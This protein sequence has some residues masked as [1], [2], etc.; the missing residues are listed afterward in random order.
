MN[1]ARVGLIKKNE[2][3]DTLLVKEYFGYPIYDLDFINQLPLDKK[4]FGKYKN[5][6]LLGRN[7]EFKHKEVDDNFRSALELIKRLKK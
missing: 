7:A 4:I 5:L 2:I 3:L 1:L 6:Y